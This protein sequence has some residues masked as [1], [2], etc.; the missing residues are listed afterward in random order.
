MDAKYIQLKNLYILKLFAKNMKK[1]L[2]LLPVALLLLS[3]CNIKPTDKGELW[4]NGWGAKIS[5]DDN[6][7]TDETVDKMNTYIDVR[8]YLDPEV[9]ETINAYL[10]RSSWKEW[11]TDVSKV[12]TDGGL[13]KYNPEDEYLKKAYASLNAS[14]SA[15]FDP[16][17]KKYLDAFKK[18]ILKNNELYDYY[19]NWNHKNDNLAKWKTLHQEFTSVIDEYDNI[20]P[21]F[22]DNYDEW[23]L[24][25]QLDNMRYYKQQWKTAKYAM[26]NISLYKKYV[27]N[28]VDAMDDEI[29]S[30]QTIDTS[31]LEKYIKK[32]D[33][34]VEYI[35]W[36]TDKDVIA[37]DMWSKNVATFEEFRKA[38]QE[39]KKVT[40]ELFPLLKNYDKVNLDTINNLIDK[41]YDIEESL[42]E[43]RNK[44]ID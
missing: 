44:T 22:I 31:D 27:M 12:P 35:N 9:N 20:Y 21:D 7:L 5:F 8:N 18:L 38:A 39:L 43:L 1:L 19:H 37:N 16:I 6:D 3:A 29:N 28:E 15:K 41:W 42:I 2:V 10:D 14:G 24:A 4:A 23:F 34:A 33:E 40:D 30:N 17:A 13:K 32:Y 36:Q 26:E 25:L 11:P